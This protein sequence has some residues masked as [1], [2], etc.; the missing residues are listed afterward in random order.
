MVHAAR[1]S[2]RAASGTTTFETIPESLVDQVG[3]FTRVQES[4][5]PGWT[6]FINN[7]C[8]FL[9][10]FLEHLR[11]AFRALDGV[12]AIELPAYLGVAIVE[13]KVSHPVILAQTLEFASLKP[14]A[15][16]ACATV[17]PGTAIRYFFH[18]RITLW[19][20]H[21]SHSRFRT[22]TILVSCPVSF[23]YFREHRIRQYKARFA[24]NIAILAKSATP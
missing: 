23:Y 13:D 14:Q 22:G 4:T 15:L 2:L 19:T 7:V 6:D 16:A 21:G 11:P 17:N 18:Q 10:S 8:L 3:K 5:M 1:Q 20:I 12:Y 24:D 9:V